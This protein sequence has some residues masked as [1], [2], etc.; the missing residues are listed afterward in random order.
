M[1]STCTNMPMIRRSTSTLRPRTLSHCSSRRMSRCIRRYRGLTEGQPTQAE[2]HQDSGYVVGFSPAAAEV[3]MASTRIDV[4]KTVRDLVVVIDSQ[5]SLSTRWPSWNSPLPATVHS[6][7]DL[8]GFLD[9]K[10][11][12]KDTEFIQFRCHGNG[13][14]SS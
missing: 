2:P 4:S 8:S 11:L 5:L 6:E 12:P 7:N 14:Q 10:N 1:A 13:G 3:P 9:P